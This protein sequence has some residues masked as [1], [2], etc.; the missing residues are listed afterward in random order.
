MERRNQELYPNLQFGSGVR[1]GSN[2]TSFKQGTLK[3]TD[4][5]LDIAINGDGFFTVGVINDNG[6]IIG[7]LYTR[8]GSF[9]LNAINDDEFRLE[10][11]EGN[12][13]LDVN[14][15]PII[16][17]ENISEDDILIKE[18]GTIYIKNHESELYAQLNIVAF[19]NPDGLERAGGS[20][21]YVPEGVENPVQYQTGEVVQGYLEVSNV[22]LAEEMT[23]LI[24]AQRA[25]QLNSRVLQTS[26]EMER[27]ANNLRG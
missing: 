17:N 14:G 19:V 4:N 15:N 13:V 1:V 25:Y 7:E 23:Q 21:F 16:F 26:D 12:P 11:R 2:R 20:Y 8:N 5:S 27:L 18:D 3:P 10:T 6:A 9:R 22:E 24:M